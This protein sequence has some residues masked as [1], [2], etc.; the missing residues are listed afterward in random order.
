[1]KQQN[2]KII[3]TSTTALKS[4][5]SDQEQEIIDSFSANN[6][7]DDDNAKQTSVK[8]KKTREMINIDVKSNQSKK[9]KNKTNRKSSETTPNNQEILEENSSLNGL[10]ELISLN[11]M[12]SVKHETEIKDMLKKSMESQEKQFAMIINSLNTKID[13]V[14]KEKEELKIEITNL[15]EDRKNNNFMKQSSDNNMSNV[16][17]EFCKDN[18]HRLV[19]SPSNGFDS[20]AKLLVLARVAMN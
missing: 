8:K 15:K 13:D 3:K 20:F 1:V 14:I 4:T 18:N 9:S 19:K 2:K 10:I 6:T 5:N 11:K 7:S 17:H 12:Q 16:M